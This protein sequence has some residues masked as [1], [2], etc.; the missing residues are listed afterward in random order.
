MAIAIPL[1]NISVEEKIQ[2]MEIIWMTY[3]IRQTIWNPPHGMEMS[4]VKEKKPY[5]PGLMNL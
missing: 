5:N 1:E 4:C 3:A 2:V